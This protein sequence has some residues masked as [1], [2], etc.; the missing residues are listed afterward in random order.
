MGIFRWLVEPPAAGLGIEFRN[1]QLVLAR[2]ADKRGRK[3]LDLCLK[4]PLPPDVIEFSMLEPNIKDPEGLSAFLKQILEQAGVRRRRIA[5]TLPDTLAR[6]SVTELP[7]APRS[8]TEVAELLRF[9]LKKSLPF[10]TNE[11]RIAFEPVPGKTPSYLNGVMHED[12][13]SQ[14]EAL[15][16]GLGFHVGVVET[17]SLSLLNLWQ[18]VADRDIPA[19][20]D[21][22]FVNAEE[23]YFSVILV[24]NRVPLLLRTLGQRTSSSPGSGN[25]LYQLDDI[26]REIVPTLIFH[27]EKLDGGFPARI[28]FR[29]LRPDLRDLPD[30]L[31]EQFGAPVEYFDLL[32]V[33]AMGEKLPVEESLS[34]LVGAAAGAAHGKVV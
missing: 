6:V 22:F 25:G 2:F 31:E 24:R 18:T 29:S 4:A 1:E 19:S 20:S 15:L 8:R 14:Y 32:R 21:Y 33:V 3:E 23:R 30:V 9:R 28:Y 26:V 13:V 10:G 16:S 17:S 34:T 5:V 7:E 11:A 27:R 12:V